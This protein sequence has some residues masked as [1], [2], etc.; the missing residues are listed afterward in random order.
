MKQFCKNSFYLFTWLEVTLFQL[1]VK[2][3]LLAQ[4]DL[5]E[6]VP[7]CRGDFSEM[8]EVRTDDQWGFFPP[9]S[10]L[11]YSSFHTVTL[12]SCNFFN[13]FF[14]PQEGK[15]NHHPILCSLSCRTVSLTPHHT[16]WVPLPQILRILN[17]VGWC[18]F[19]VTSGTCAQM[20]AELKLVWVVY[21]MEWELEISPVALVPC[22]LILHKCAA[23]T[24]RLFSVVL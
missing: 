18:Q 11:S 5:S 6:Q 23:L 2:M 8:E 16:V 22:L 20:L 19:C 12:S 4:T 9:F 14:Y 17:S 10:L 3:L 15:K 13:P 7:G 1:P 21:S 24:F